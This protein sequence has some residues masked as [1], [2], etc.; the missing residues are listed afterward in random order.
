MS[1]FIPWNSQPLND[2]TVKYGKGKFVDLEGHKTHY[3]EK[4][5]GE[6]I[7][8]IHGFFYDSD[9]WVSN[10]DKLAEH[11]KVYALDLWGF[12]YSTREPLD[13]SYQ[14][15][16][17]QVLLFMDALGIE[18][19]HIAGQS[20]GGG[21]VIWF[22]VQNRSRVNKIILVDP[23]GV[24]H[25]IPLTGKIFNL[26]RVGEFFL[27][28]KSNFIRKKNLADLWFYKKDLITESYFEDVTRF[29]KIKGTTEC[30][31][32]IL[33]KEFF[34]TLSDELQQLAQ[35]DIPILIVWGKEDKAIP[36]KMGEEMHRILK[37]SRLEIFDQAGHMPQYECS[38]EFNKLALEFLQQ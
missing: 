35:L 37:G 8:L 27:G 11:Y 36:V 6:P 19:A 38:E 14:L 3:L 12:G 2:W 29:H 25:G 20:M 33:R 4:G 34:N 7:V 21:T 9:L 28:L 1:E 26:P 22:G 30:M 32:T 31:L 15:F 13:F 18:R 17:D 24:P 10:I 5:E 23:A 16:S